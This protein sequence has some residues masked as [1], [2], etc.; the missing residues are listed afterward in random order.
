MPRGDLTPPAL[1]S[2][3]MFGNAAS[4][5]GSIFVSAPGVA[6]VY[7]V[8]Q[9]GSGSGAAS[10]PMA[11]LPLQTTL[12]DAISGASSSAQKPLSFDGMEQSQDANRGTRWLMVLNEVGGGGGTV[13]VRLYEA[14]N[15]NAAI[16]QK[17]VTISPYQQLRLDKTDSIACGACLHC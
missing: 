13:S 5:Q 6:K 15:R 14:G 7:A 2:K 8:L 12:S 3:E 10:R 1:S 4:T 16:A 17:D 11:T 9:G